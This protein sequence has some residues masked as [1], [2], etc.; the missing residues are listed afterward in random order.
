M[1]SVVLTITPTAL[2]SVATYKVRALSVKRITS[3]RHCS[4]VNGESAT[5]RLGTI[6]FSKT[7]QRLHGQTPMPSILT[8]QNFVYCSTTTK[9]FALLLVNLRY[10]SG[11]ELPQ[12]G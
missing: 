6:M 11:L 10:D 3:E 8:K 12:A 7:K 2:N 1:C 9:E 5:Q 4:G